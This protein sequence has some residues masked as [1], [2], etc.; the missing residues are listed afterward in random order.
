MLE[1]L[2][3]IGAW[4][5][6]EITEWSRFLNQPKPEPTNKKG[7]TITHYVVGVVFDLDEDSV[8][9]DANALREYDDEYDPEELKALSIQGG[10]NKAIYTTVEPPK[11]VQLFKTFFGK[12]EKKQATC[13]ELT[14]AIDKNFPQFQ[15]T[16]FYALL[17]QIFSL[18]DQ[19]LEKAVTDEKFDYKVFF[20]PLQLGHNDN[21]VLV[22]AAVKATDLGYD[23]PTP[24]AQLTI[25][26]ELLA[27]KFLNTPTE[28]ANTTT[29]LC[30]ASGEP[31]ED[32]TELNL[33]ARYSLNKMFVT[34]TKN[35]ASL[36]D[37]KAFSLNYQVSLENQEKLDLASS[38]LLDKYKTRIADVDHVIIPQFLEHSDI[39]LDLTLEKISL[40]AQSLFTLQSEGSLAAGVK[41]IQNYGGNVF[42]INF[43]AYE[44]DGNFFKSISLIKDVSR[45]HFER[46]LAAFRDVN[47]E[48]EAL[49]DTVDWHAVTTEYGK[50]SSFNVYLAYGLIPVRR[51][52]EKK[53]IA[54][55]LFKAMLERRTVTKEQLYG[56][57]SELML[58]HYYGR[59]KSYTNVRAYGDDYFGLAIRDSVFKYLAFMQ[60]LRKLNL[61]NME[62]EEPTTTTEETNQD[63]ERRVNDFFA[64]MQLNDAQKA[65]FFLGRMLNAV[66][67]IQRDKN[68]TVIDKL[69]YNGMDKDDIVRLRLSLFEKAKQY[70][71]TQNV[72]FSDAHFGQYFDFEQWKM[73]PQEALFFILTGYSFGAKKKPKDSS[74]ND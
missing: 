49:T 50:P 27:A 48:M 6:E 58:C 42:W 67:Y 70:G 1:T 56:H 11:L 62:S 33:T 68:K 19:F 29:K 9:I 51:D 13:G 18:R 74:N 24:I 36:F 63:R 66:A 44:S 37:K 41:R 16:D 71:K 60:V 23:A 46:M 3:K 22:F 32:V 59:Y 40:D 54:L 64:Q 39:D 61:I 73:N 28:E 12:P 17:Q 26:Q 14:E 34:E 57:F 15:D 55:Q 5:S 72:V 10:N 4:Q 45:F 30:Y 7:E 43:L 8:Y 25:Y 38:F 69:N 20:E 53:N 21:V 2:L 35:Y 31:K 65:M 47:R 52:K